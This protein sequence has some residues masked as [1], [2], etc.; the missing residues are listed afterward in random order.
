MK[1]GA[2]KAAALVG[3]MGFAAYYNQR[4]ASSRVKRATLQTEMFGAPKSAQ[5]V[6][7]FEDPSEQDLI[8]FLEEL[9][10]VGEDNHFLGDEEDVRNF[11]NVRV[12][13]KRL[14]KNKFGNADWNKAFQAAHRKRYNSLANFVE[15]NE[16]SYPT[17]ASL[18]EPD[19]DGNTLGG[20]AYNGYTNTHPK[21]EAVLAETTIAGD[22]SRDGIFAEGNLLCGFIVPNTVPL[23][24]DIG[25][26]L[27]DFKMYWNFILSFQSKLEQYNGR[28]NSVATPRLLLGRNSNKVVWQSR[29][30]VRFDKRR[31]P[32]KR[33]ESY[34]A[35][36]VMQGLQ[37]YIMRTALDLQAKVAA[38]AASPSA[39]KDCY[40]FWI[41]HEIGADINQ[42]L[43]PESQELFTDLNKQCTIMHIFVGFDDYDPVIQAYATALVPGL[44][45]KAPLDNDFSG[46][47]MVKKHAGL[48]DPAFIKSLTTYM[49]IAKHRAGC[50][51]TDSIYQ[52]P[53]T[54]P[55]PT[56]V[57]GDITALPP[58][59]APDLGG[60]TAGSDDFNRELTS[61]PTV[62]G[63]IEAITGE[64]RVSVLDS[65]C[66][67]DFF[68][69]SAYDSELRTCCEDGKVKSWAVDGSDPCF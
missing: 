50:R 58:T 36:P 67:V 65:C 35:R 23:G 24:S 41:H 69:G 45:M 17:A 3:L 29:S 57:A 51:C 12:N 56:G 6:S 2:L 7:N 60:T 9:E 42:L 13:F 43:L 66:G 34:N 39:D 40:F 62:A 64:P 37:P 25:Q 44:Q 26:N 18:E 54:Q 8:R 22:I 19:A 38:F 10:W 33:Y 1:E 48:T 47:W 63:V 21:I 16:Y 68:T 5:N 59:D 53:V 30:P 52:A 28:S 15:F 46:I 4:T 14:L 20:G 11:A 32:W 27:I 31:F 61:A 55:P 49:T